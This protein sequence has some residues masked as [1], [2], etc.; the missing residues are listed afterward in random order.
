MPLK[1]V[2]LESLPPLH[3]QRIREALR[4]LTA[5]SVE[6]SGAAGVQLHARVFETA[7]AA[8]HLVHKGQSAVGLTADM[9]DAGQAGLRLLHSIRKLT[10]K[11]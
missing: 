9:A 1:K 10:G 8:L 5:E 6:L 4:V 7:I 11:S 2:S 3:P